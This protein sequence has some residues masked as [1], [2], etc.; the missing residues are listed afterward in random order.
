VNDPKPGTMLTLFDALADALEAG[1]AV[2]DGPW[3]DRILGRLE[4]AVL[5]TPDL[6]PKLKAAGVVDAGALGMYLFLDGF[7]TV[8]AGQDQAARPVAEIFAGRLRI[9]KSFAEEGEAGC[10]IDSVLRVGKE[11]GERLD[12]IAALGESVVALREGDYLKV[13]LHA[14]DSEKARGELAAF[15][16][17]LRFRADDLNRQ[18]RA[19]KRRPQD[20][21][22]HVMTDAAGSIGRREAADLGMT[23]LSSYITLGSRSLPETQVEPEELYAAMRSGARV[24]TAQASLSERSEHYRSALSRFA[25]VLYLPVGSA[26][27]GNFRDA[28]AWREKNDPGG[29]FTV[30]DSGAASGRLGLLALATARLALAGR[31]ADGV[32]RFAEKGAALC[33]EYVFLDTLKYLAQGGRLSRPNAFF[34]DM[35]RMKPVISPLPDG[36]RKVGVVRNQKEQLDFIRR[37]LE[38]AFGSEGNGLIMVEYTDNGEW[39]AA[40]VRPLVDRL[41]PKA[42]IILQPM[43]LTAG[44]HMGPGT[45]AVAFWPAGG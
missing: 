16:E 22:I 8:L 41:C 39:V 26:F 27:T 37:R 40:F 14:R 13:H 18:I 25:A 43:S 28:A 34:G 45:W 42:E 15:G 30:I 6:L 31:D 35:L 19:F 24:S 36:A 1:E 38:A 10:C 12:G 5:A 23:V 20:Q 7:F 4:E 21:A 17:V 32:I 44:A 9:S 2:F 29:R 11:G 33:E 3:R